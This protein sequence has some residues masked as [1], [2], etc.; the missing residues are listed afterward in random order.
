MTPAEIISLIATTVALISAAAAWS[1]IIA[2]RRNATDTIE[3][4]I[5]IAARNSRAVVVSGNRQKWIDAV[6]DDL[7]NFISTR[8]RILALKSAGSFEV[9]GRDA[10]LAEERELR[11]RLVMLYARIEMRLNHG[12]NDHRVLLTALSR[13]DADPSDEAEATVRE[14]G[15]KIFSDEWKRLKKEASGI[16]PFVKEAVPPRRV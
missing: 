6:R 13:H 2:N 14:A 8:S 7:A 5:N 15:R 4:Q 3:S 11:A 9:A 1:A 12:E 10:L 16:D